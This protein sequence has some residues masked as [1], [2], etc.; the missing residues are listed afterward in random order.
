MKYTL[1]T[2]LVCLLAISANAQKAS[3]IDA[4][5]WLIGTWENTRVKPGETAHEVWTKSADGYLSGMG[6]TIQD[7]DT[8]FVERLRIIEQHGSFYYV[9][10]VSHNP[11]PVM[12]KITETGPASFVSENPDHDFPKKIAYSYDGQV[13]TAT[14]SAGEKKIPF[15]FR[16]KG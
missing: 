3:G 7:G 13:L 2:S 9:A 4:F 10:I 12:F 8:V 15:R 1:L 5:E 11:A 14:I 6:V 16:K